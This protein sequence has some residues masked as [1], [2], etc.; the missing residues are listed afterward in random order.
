MISQEPLREF[1]HPFGHCALRAG[2]GHGAALS[3]TLHGSLRA[4]VRHA[5]GGIYQRQESTCQA[6]RGVF[7]ATSRDTTVRALRDIGGHGT[8]QILC[9][10][11]PENS[12]GRAARG[13]GDPEPGFARG[14]GG[15]VGVRDGGG[16]P[17]AGRHRSLLGFFLA[18]CPTT[19]VS[20]WKVESASTTELMLAFHRNLRSGRSK[21]LALQAAALK[22]L[23]ESRYRHPFYWAGFVVVGDGS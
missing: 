17:G 20:Q 2:P 4:Q 18:G 10:L 21:A 6:Q 13:L 11:S 3:V 9:P 23:R 7:E 12:R 16:R 8:L 5:R 15:A 19:V 14:P 1:R 22:L